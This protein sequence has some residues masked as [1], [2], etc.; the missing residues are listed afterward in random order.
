M[1]N[2]PVPVN[3]RQPLIF[4]FKGTPIT[5]RLDM[6]GNPWFDGPEVCNALAIANP[7]N[8]YKRLDDDEKTPLH[9]IEG[10]SP[11]NG[12]NRIYVSESGLYNLIMRSDK[13]EARAFKRWITREVL[14]SIRKTGSYITPSDTPPS[15]LDIV[16]GMVKALRNH[17]DRMRR[18]EARQDVQDQEREYMSIVGYAAYNQR[19]IDSTAASQLGRWATRYCKLNNI[20]IG[21]KKDA[22][23]GW[24]NTYPDNVLRIVFDA[25]KSQVPLFDE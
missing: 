25:W 1:S 8:A 5:I 18:I 22:L 14:P 17:E 3:P 21:K 15:A 2:L 4:N 23:R 10:A 19:H 13:Q 11:Q 12:I 24:I 9:Q 7:S 20:H 6:E 16:E